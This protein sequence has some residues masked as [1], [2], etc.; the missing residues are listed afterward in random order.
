MFSDIYECVSLK[1]NVCQALNPLH[2]FI[3]ITWKSADVNF[4]G[5][6]IHV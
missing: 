1:K 5:L 3:I 2:D 6:C 4:G